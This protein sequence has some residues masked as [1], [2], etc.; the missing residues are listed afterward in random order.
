MTDTDREKTNEHVP[1]HGH[2]TNSQYLVGFASA[3]LL[4]AALA[5]G[6]QAWKWFAEN[7]GSYIEFLTTPMFSFADLFSWT[8]IL[9]LVG[10]AI[11]G[12]KWGPRP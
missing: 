12:L 11:A 9:L 3:L 8:A 1:T 7:H 2:K 10:T 4:V 6:L 5:L